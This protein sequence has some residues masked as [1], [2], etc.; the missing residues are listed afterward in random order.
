MKIAELHPLLSN[1]YG[2]QALAIDTGD[3]QTWADTYL[4]DG[5]YS[6]PSYG[7]PYT[8]RDELIEFGNSF[9][10]RSPCAK[11]LVLNV[12][13]K[14]I[15]GDRASVILTYVIVSG[16]PGGECTILR[17]VTA[18]DDVVLVD[19]APKLASRTIKF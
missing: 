12:H 18:F 17:T 15:N 9:P 8:G 1:M 5:S 13:V 16:E 10:S 6:S 11:H 4:E 14:E 19:G 2:A 7:R 3:G